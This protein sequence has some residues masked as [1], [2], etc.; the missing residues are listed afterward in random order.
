[1]LDQEVAP[2]AAVDV[3]HPLGERSRWRSRWFGQ[4]VDDRGWVR[5][6]DSTWRVLLLDLVLVTV[7]VTIALVVILRLWDAHLRVPFG[8]GGDGLQHARDAKTIVQTGWVQTTPRLGAPFGQE[9]YDFPVSGDNGNYLIM[10]LM[11]LITSDWALIVNAFFLFSFYT[12]GWAA[13][14]CLRWLRCGRL[15][16]GVC[17]ILFAFAPYHFGRGSG[18][19]L[20]SSYFVVPIAALLAVRAASGRSLVHWKSRSPEAPQ[21]TRWQAIR[22]HLGATLPW[23][24]LCA[25]CAS[26]GSYYTFFAM[27][28]ILLAGIVVAATRRSVRMIVIAVGY[29]LAIG[30][31]FVFNLLPNLLYRRA[32]GTDFEV[33]RRLPAELDLYGLRLIQ[34]V[35]PVPGEIFAPMRSAAQE[36]LKGYPSEQSQFFGLVGAAALLAMLAWLAVLIV[37]GGLAVEDDGRLQ[38]RALL[39]FLCVAWILIATTG[40]LDWFATLV[41]FTQLRAWNR[42]SILLMFLV[43]AWLALTVGPLVHR[44]VALS[45]RRRALVPALALVVVVVGLVDQ[46]STSLVTLPNA[47]VTS[48]DS[49]KAFFTGI[50]AELPQGSM[51]YQLPYRPYPESPPT[52]GSADYDLLR[53]YLQTE[54]LRWSYGGMKGR[55]SDWQEQLQGL[56]AADLTRDILAV[57][58]QAYVIDLAGYPDYGAQIER[59]ITT[60]TGRQPRHSADQRWSFF[61][62]TGLAPTFGSPAALAALKAQLL[63][64]PR[65]TFQGCYGWEGTGTNRLT[66]CGPSGTIEVVDPKPTGRPQVLTASVASPQGTGVLTLEAGGHEVEVHVAPTPTPITVAVPAGAEVGVRFTADIPPVPSPGDPRDL[67]YQLIS[68]QVHESP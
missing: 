1:V 49:D 43:L 34:M 3:R 56:S 53:P 14:L 47:Y 30:A 68:P 2:P 21:R 26:F 59:D 15:S 45:P 37:R 44:W 24:V 58:Y 63:D 39:A 32:H 9:L 17:A 48:F 25:A 38:V 50:E 51:V 7:V 28:T 13:Y 22:H 41:G 12:V 36:L 19:L 61:D 33:A 46:G 57:G 66:W 27:I 35:T 23:L 11:A 67:R 6:P 62:L 16:A 29:E 52:Y 5:A 54:S 8:Y 60:V 10:K 64:E 42:V 31:V 55:E 18:H 40:G 20:L 65:V 4:S